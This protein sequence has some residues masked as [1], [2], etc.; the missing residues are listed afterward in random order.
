MIVVRNAIRLGTPAW[1]T[2]GGPGPLDVETG[3]LTVRVLNLHEK[4]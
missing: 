1:Q 2:R 4:V 3:E